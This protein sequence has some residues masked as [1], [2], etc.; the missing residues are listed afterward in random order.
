[1][2]VDES[3]PIEMGETVGKYRFTII[4]LL[5]AMAGNVCLPLYYVESARSNYSYG[6]AVYATYMGVVVYVVLIIRLML[7]YGKQLP[8]KKKKAIYMT[9]E[10]PDTLLVEQLEKEQLKQI[11]KAIV[12]FDVDYLQ[13]VELVM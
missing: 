9:T 10:N 1:M 5:I 12:E 13:D 4:P 8:L 7:Q 6:P 3:A 11:H 2:S